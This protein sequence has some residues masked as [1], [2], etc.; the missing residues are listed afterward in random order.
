MTHNEVFIIGN[1]GKDP[2]LRHTNSGKAVCN[3]TLATKDGNETNWHDVVC[4]EQSAEY[5]GEHVRK[6]HKLCVV[7]RLKYHSYETKNGDRARKSEI[8]AYRVIAMSHSR[9]E[10]QYPGQGPQ[11]DYN[12]DIDSDE[13][14]F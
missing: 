5:V 12:N 2:E 10:V 6:G 11:G 14:P 4:W 8:I 13:I 7:G 9:D 3:L 1:V